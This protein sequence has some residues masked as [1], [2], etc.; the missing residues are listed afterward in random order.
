VVLAVSTGR[1][2]GPSAWGRWAGYECLAIGL[3]WCSPLAP[4]AHP[5]LRPGVA[6]PVTIALL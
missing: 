6:G 4:A 5:G 3:L 1:S 2:P